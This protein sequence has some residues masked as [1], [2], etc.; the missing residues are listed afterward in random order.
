MDR[1]CIWYS[2]IQVVL[3]WKTI[4]LRFQ[5]LMRCMK[6]KLKTIFF[7]LR[8]RGRR[9]RLG[10]VLPHAGGTVSPHT[11]LLLPPAAPR[12]GAVQ[13]L[14]PGCGHY[15][16]GR[17]RHPPPPHPLPHWQQPA[18]LQLANQPK[19]IA[20]S[21]QNNNLRNLKKK[22]FQSFKK[23][24]IRRIWTNCFWINFWEFSYLQ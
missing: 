4:V 6:Q 8:N 10:H 21:S 20:S 16:G 11:P 15:P 14:P 9:R 12:S 18:L 17:W 7:W 13:H 5:T 2:V 19:F 1:S 22:Q 3:T 24:L 23:Y